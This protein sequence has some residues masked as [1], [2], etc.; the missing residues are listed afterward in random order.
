MDSLASNSLLA[1]SYGKPEPMKVGN[2]M[3]V[4]LADMIRETM[5]VSNF[6][7]RGPLFLKRL[8]EWFFSQKLCQVELRMASKN[9]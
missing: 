1:A 5:K 3:R 9:S 7:L 4:A 8:S 2:L 6:H